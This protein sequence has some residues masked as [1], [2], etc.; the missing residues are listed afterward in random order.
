[1][2]YPEIR[3][4]TANQTCLIQASTWSR[5][6]VTK[7]NPDPWDMQHGTVSLEPG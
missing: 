5:A 7:L 6:T 4:K 3:G 2:S 1:M